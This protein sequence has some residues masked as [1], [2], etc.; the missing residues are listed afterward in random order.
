[1]HMVPNVTVIYCLSEI[2]LLLENL[3]THC[4]SVEF[5]NLDR[6]GCQCIPYMLIYR[7]TMN[8]SLM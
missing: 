3:D 8:I 6:R 4:P 1:M 5:L 7:L 2:L